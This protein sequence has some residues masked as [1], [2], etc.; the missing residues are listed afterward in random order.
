MAIQIVVCFASLCDWLDIHYTGFFMC[1]VLDNVSPQHN[2]GCSFCNAHRLCPFLHQSIPLQVVLMI[3]LKAN[4]VKKRSTTTLMHKLSE[5]GASGDGISKICKH[6]K[7]T[8]KSNL[9]AC[10]LSHPAVCTYLD[11]RLVVHKSQHGLLCLPRN[12]HWSLSELPRG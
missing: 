1:V 12:F 5:F 4:L 6:M 2:Q 8:Q 9:Y 10:S 3:M 11:R 7:Y